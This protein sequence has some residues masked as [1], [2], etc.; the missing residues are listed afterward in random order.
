M[1]AITAMHGDTVRVTQLHYVRAAADLG[2]FSAA[3]AALGVTQPSLSRGIVALERTLGGALFVRSTTGVALTPL[4][5]RIMPHLHDVL[6]S[7][8]SLLGEARAATEADAQPLRL[9]VSPLI[10]PELIGRAFQATRGRG[11]AALVLREDDLAGLRAGLLARELD[12]ILVPAVTATD[13]SLRRCEIDSEE[14]RYRPGSTLSTPDDDRPV[15]LTELADQSLVMVGE[16]CGLNTF[17]RALF[18]SAGAALAPYPGVADSYR[19]VE[20]WAGLGLG[21]AVLPRSR[22]RHPSRTRPVHFR[23]EPVRIRYE[24]LWPTGSTREAAIGDLVDTIVD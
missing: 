3:A 14:L 13:P 2:S 12:V 20:D 8:G 7:L 15:E 5:K 6:G 4:A 11:P 10:R 23:G 17:I 22:F 16:S 1:T 9:G 24:A 19:S 18:T 21:A